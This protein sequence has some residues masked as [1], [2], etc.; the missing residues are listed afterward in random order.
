MR[1][2]IELFRARNYPG[3][4]AACNAA[5]EDDPEHIHLRLLLAKALLA[6]RRDTEAQQQISECMRR[7]PSCPTPYQLLGTLALRRDELK[8]AEIF[9]KE[10]L[11]L[12][13]DNQEVAELLTIVLSL[14]QPIAAG[15]K[16]P[17]APVAVGCPLSRPRPRRRL[18]LGTESD[19][20]S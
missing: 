20:D 3:V 14:L 17:A 19:T 5:M 16:L 9:F 12:Q 8:S 1:A 18:A 4:V 10:S 6:L 2:A 13:P 15:E 7:D 11:R